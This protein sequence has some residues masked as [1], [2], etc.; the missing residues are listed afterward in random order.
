M[1]RNYKGKP[2]KA[3][4]NIKQETNG[5]GTRFNS[6]AFRTGHRPWSHIGKVE[7]KIKELS[8]AMQTCNLSTWEPEAGGS[9]V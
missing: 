5:A 7:L 6:K 8:V 4:R 1:P 3:R 9:Q 2:A